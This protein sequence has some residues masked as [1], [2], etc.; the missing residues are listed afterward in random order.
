MNSAITSPTRTKEI[1]I[2]S[3]DIMLLVI[4]HFLP[5]FYGANISK[6][7]FFRPMAML[8]VSPFSLFF[9]LNYIE[10]IK[11]EDYK[12]E[13][14]LYSPSRWRYRLMDK[15]KFFLNIKM[16]YIIQSH[17]VKDEDIVEEI[18]MFIDEVEV[19][20]EK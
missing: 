4:K 8:K 12:V 10:N 16:I 2:N 11:K 19:Y 13:P 1:H 3:D 14:F 20:Y 6:T 17:S 18:I 15:P 7:I 5:Y 9:M